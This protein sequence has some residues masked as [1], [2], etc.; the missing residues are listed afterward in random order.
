MVQV[1]SFNPRAHTG[2]DMGS[3]GAQNYNYVSIHAPTRD[4]TD[5]AYRK[6]NANMFQSTRPHGTRL[7]SA[8]AAGTIFLFQS[9]RPHGTRP[10]CRW[11]CTGHKCF[12][13]R[14]HTG[15]DRMRLIE[16]PTPICFN[17]RAHTGR[18]QDIRFMGLPEM[19]SIHA[20]TR[21]ATTAQTVSD[22]FEGFQST[23]PHGTRLKGKDSCP[24]ITHGFNPRA[25]TGRD[26]VLLLAYSPVCL[27]QSTRP[28]GTRPLLSFCP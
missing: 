22:K 1:I 9:T 4:A 15:R 12:N 27:F 8:G 6:A 7:L 25:H 16:R 14:A 24:V 26:S 5:A 20:P 2:R 10:C 23:R 19:V 21:D 17:P 13:P 18:D 11:C 3:G 28:H